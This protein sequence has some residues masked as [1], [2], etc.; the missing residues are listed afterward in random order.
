MNIYVSNLSFHTIEEDLKNLFS[1]FGIVNSVKIITDR[2]TNKSR[3]FGFIEMPSREE[4]ENA[5]SRLHG[6]EIEGRALS[7][8][9]A[10][11]REESRNSGYQSSGYK[12]TY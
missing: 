3:G 5:I 10:R 7:V 2:L 11:E 9:M 8:S 1:Q 12:R 6:K 4:G